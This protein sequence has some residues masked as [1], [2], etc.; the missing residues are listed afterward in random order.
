VRESPACE[1]RMLRC[2]RVASTQGR[3][4]GNSEIYSAGNREEK[5]QTEK[6]Q[7]ML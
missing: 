7:D 2:E 5:M 6:T 4:N 3:E 1:P